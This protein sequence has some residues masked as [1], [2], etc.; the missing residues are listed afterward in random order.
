MAKL[1]RTKGAESW[2]DIPG[3]DGW[4]QVSDEGRVRSW[5]TRANFC[6]RAAVPR[7]L[8]G[9]HNM[10][11]YLEVKLTHAVLGKVRVLVHHLVLATFV[12]H[13]PHGMVCDH[14]NAVRNDNRPENL[15]WVTTRENVQHA[16]R[17]GRMDGRPGARSQSPLCLDDVLEIRRRRA[18]GEKLKPIAEAFGV[19]LSTVTNIAT[20]KTWAEV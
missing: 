15:R 16:N 11:G 3:F 13:R 1:S 10:Q 17:L 4:Y 19:S 20:R 14:V 2:Q 7:V 6:K 5:R 18:A 9:R 8:S 12:A